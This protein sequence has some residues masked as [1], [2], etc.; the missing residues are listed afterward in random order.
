MATDAQRKHAVAVMDYMRSK[1]AQL[2]YPPGDQR[3]WRDYQDWNW[4]EQT[5]EHVLNGGGRWQGDCSDF[6][7]FVLK[8]AGIW[9]ARWGPGWTGSHLQLLPRYTD[10]KQAF[11]GALVV[12]GYPPGHHEAIVHTADPTKGDPLCASHG[13]PGFDLLR[14]SQIAVGQP[15]GITFLSIAHL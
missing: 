1:S 9:P 8:L 12:F 7:S 14:V 3:T 6:S 13:R 11:P 5:L 15:P 2:D 4:N 10:G